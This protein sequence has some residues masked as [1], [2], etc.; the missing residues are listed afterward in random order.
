MRDLVKPNLLIWDDFEM[1]QMDL[2]MIQDFLEVIE[3]R[4]HHKRDVALSAQLPVKERPFPQTDCGAYA[5]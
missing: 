1:K 3:E 2:G 5:D 4:Y